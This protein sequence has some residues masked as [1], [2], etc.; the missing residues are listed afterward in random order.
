VG[1]SFEL[2]NNDLAR[3]GEVKEIGAS[4]GKVGCAAAEAMGGVIKT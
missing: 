1:F 4:R 2:I 3:R